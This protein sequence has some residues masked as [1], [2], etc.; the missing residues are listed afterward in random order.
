MKDCTGEYIVISWGARRQVAEL[1]RTDRR[2]LR[3]EVKPIG[4]VIIFAPSSAT[5]QTIHSRVM[6]RRA[7]I[8]RQLDRIKAQPAA[9]PPRHFISG[10]THLV[11]GKPCRLSIEQRDEPEVRVEGNRLYIFTPHAER[12]GECRRLLME[13]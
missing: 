2:V 10:E 7:W 1:R 8:F 3:V 11:L 9:T 13:F 4:R 12:Q 5:L 6:R